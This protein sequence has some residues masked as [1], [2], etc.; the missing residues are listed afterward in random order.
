MNLAIQ[1]DSDRV[2][3]EASNPKSPAKSTHTALASSLLL[4]RV[5]EKEI[6]K[7]RTKSKVKAGAWGSN[8]SE[9]L[10]RD[11][12]K[13]LKVRTNVRAGKRAA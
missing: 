6:K 9:T 5:S 7:M 10:V 3:S 8:H 11:N 13:N 12:A 1:A 2:F 4:G